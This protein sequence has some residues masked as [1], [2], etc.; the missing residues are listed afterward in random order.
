VAAYEADTSIDKVNLGVGAYRDKNAKPWILPVMRKV[1]KK[2]RNKVV[3]PLMVFRLKRYWKKFPSITM[4][5]CPSL[6]F[7]CST[8]RLKV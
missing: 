1:G 8:L 7:R 3:I 5:T 4:K 2:D 6:A